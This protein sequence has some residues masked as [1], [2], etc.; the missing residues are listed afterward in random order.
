MGACSFRSIGGGGAAVVVVALVLA[1]SGVRRAKAEPLTLRACLADAVAESSRLAASNEAV[2]EARAEY[3]SLRGKLLPV[4]SL[5]AHLL[6]WDSGHDL[7]VD[8]SALGTLLTPFQAL[9]KDDAKAVLASLMEDG[10]QLEVHAPFTAETTVAVAQPVTQLYRVTAGLKARDELVEAALQDAVTSRSQLED[11]VIHAW[12]S[13]VTATTLLGTID[14]GLRQVDAIEQKVQALLQADMVERSALLKVQ[15]RRAELVK[16]RFRATKGIRLAS[17]VL[18]L[19]RGRPLTEALTPALDEELT[20]GAALEPPADVLALLAVQVEEQQDRAVA[21]RPELQ[22]GRARQRALDFSR[23]VAI[24]EA[25]PDVTLVGAYQNRRGFGALYPENAWFAGVMLEWKAWEWG[26]SAYRVKATEAHQRQVRSQLRDAE[27]RIRLDVQARRLALEEAVE[28]A[29]VVAT[30]V[31]RAREALAVEDARFV[32]QEA[33]VSD[34]LA[35]QTASQKAEND[36]TIARGRVLEART[37]LR[38]GMG[39]DPLEEV[40]P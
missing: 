30:Q 11:E 37:L 4:V 27:A 38:S 36:A 2:V 12:Y 20:A 25:L 35:A 32:A 24:G 15:V 10:L 28:Q 31:A 16:K 29:R 22:A 1:S 14:A 5:D 9:L 40:R 26:A 17:A 34:L 39:Y 7:K 6:R 3:D 33:T 13:L 8:V 21:A 23:H 18:N 19:H